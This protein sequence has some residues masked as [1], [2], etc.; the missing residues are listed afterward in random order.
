MRISPPES[1]DA[2]TNEQPVGVAAGA[3]SQ[4][5]TAAGLRSGSL[6]W[7]KEIAVIAVFY[8]VYS[9]VRD[10]RGTRPVSVAQAFHNARRVIGLERRLGLFHEA[11][12][13]HAFLGDHLVVRLLDD[14]YGSTHFIVTAGVLVLLF[15]SR[16]GLY[17]LWRNTLAVATALALVGFAFFPLMPPRLLPAQ[18]GF[19][20]TLKV[21]GGLWNFDSGPM[22]HLSDQYA[23][24][25]S[26][27]FA[28]ALWC[29]I[30]LFS[31]SRRWWTR[32]ASL[33]YPAVT[34]LCVIVTANHYFTDTAA[35]AAI[36]AVGYAAARGADRWWPRRPSATRPTEA[37]DTGP[38]AAVVTRPARSS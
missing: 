28:W 3:S 30:V 38:G 12:I 32:V 18:Y 33:A 19:T 13:Q 34:L 31:I 35:G 1:V 20:D 36:V 22:S 26:L 16:R 23:A 29:G 11:S 24:M 9:A 15:F 4:P 6:R 25:P 21:V 27:H 8:A 10:L 17:R 5:V 14:W 37:A 7:W 2:S